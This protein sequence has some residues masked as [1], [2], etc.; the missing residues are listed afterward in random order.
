MAG[1][2]PGPADKLIPTDHPPLT[3]RLCCETGYYDAFNRDNVHLVDTKADPIAAITPTGVRLASGATHDV[4]VLVFATGF[5]AGTGSL[6]RL[7]ITGRDGLTL[8][9][10]WADGHAPISG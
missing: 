5:D 7:G 9:E 10:H 4:D 2:G 6:T 8:A 3:K 1:E